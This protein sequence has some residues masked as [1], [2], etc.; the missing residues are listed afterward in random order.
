MGG[1]R[2]FASTLRRDLLVLMGGLTLLQ[3]REVEENEDPLENVTVQELDRISL[4]SP[5]QNKVNC[6][7]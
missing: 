5:K 6:T 2:S 3:K 7:K 4:M 1:A